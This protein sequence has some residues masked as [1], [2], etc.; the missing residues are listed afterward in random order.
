MNIAT[1]IPSVETIINEDG[2]FAVVIRNWWPNANSLHERISTDIPWLT[3]TTQYYSKK[4]TLIPRQMCLMAD[5]GIKHYPFPFNS[6]HANCWDDTTNN[7]YDEIRQIRD[8]IREDEWIKQMLGI[9]LE[10]NSCLANNYAKPTDKIAYHSDKEAL[11]PL[12]AVVTLSLGGSIPFIFKNKRKGSNGRY[13]RR[14]IILHN[15]DL[16]IMAGRCQELWTH[17]IEADKT[18]QR[19]PRESLTYRYINRS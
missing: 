5:K 4:E 19:L 2:A 6:I 10:F 3:M 12:N 1:M 18:G 17:G 7:V 15:G 16:T 13:P 11:G 14:E 8:Y 9:Q